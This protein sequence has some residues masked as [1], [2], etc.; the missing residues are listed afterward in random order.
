M[1]FGWQEL[2]ERCVDCK[3]FG[4]LPRCPECGGATLH[5]FYNTKVTKSRFNK[6]SG[7]HVIKPRDQTT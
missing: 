2:V 4:A 1:L 6:P 7:T 5:I 3:L